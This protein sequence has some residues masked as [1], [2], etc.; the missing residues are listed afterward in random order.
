MDADGDVTGLEIKG[1][2]GCAAVRRLDDAAQTGPA[3][4]RL[5][6]LKRNDETGASEF[7]YEYEYEYCLLL[8]PHS[9]MMN[10]EQVFQGVSSYRKSRP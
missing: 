7:E 6:Q 1:D 3:R 8:K 4:I 2:A 9:Y 5:Y 10:T